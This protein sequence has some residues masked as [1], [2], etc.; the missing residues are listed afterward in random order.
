[1]NEWDTRLIIYMNTTSTLLVSSL[2]SKAC[3]S[4]IVITSYS[5]SDTI[6]FPFIS[7]SNRY[8]WQRHPMVRTVLLHTISLVMSWAWGQYK[9]CCS[10]PLVVVVVV[11]VLAWCRRCCYCCLSLCSRERTHSVPVTVG[12]GW[13]MSASRYSCH[14]VRRMNPFKNRWLSEEKVRCSFLECFRSVQPSVCVVY[15]CA[16]GCVVNSVDVEGWRGYFR[17]GSVWRCWWHLELQ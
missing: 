11:L 4:N 10:I 6:R 16:Y 2:D 5:R 17:T 14:C 9:S 8:G 3:G 7:G 1:M 13:G 12:R 15:G